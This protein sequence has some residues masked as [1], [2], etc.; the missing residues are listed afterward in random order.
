MVKEWV[1]SAYMVKDKDAENISIK[2]KLDNR[3]GTTC[4]VETN[5]IQD[6]NQN[7]FKTHISKYTNM[8]LDEN[9]QALIKKD[10]LFESFDRTVCKSIFQ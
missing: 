8:I 7:L 6:N 1:L 5:A 3:T 10:T 4:S 9:I 2:P